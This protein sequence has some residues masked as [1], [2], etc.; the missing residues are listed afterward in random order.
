ME[1]YIRERDG[2]YQKD[3]EKIQ[4]HYTTTY[5]NWISLDAAK[6][7]WALK[8]RLKEIIESSTERRQN[9]F[10]LRTNGK[11]APVA[12]IGI[13]LVHI[14]ENLSKFESYCPVSLLDNGELVQGPTN[15]RFT[16]EYEVFK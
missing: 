6:S 7:K 15:T 1:K 3:I 5:Q 16:A 13:S 9:Y 10:S 4:N 8:S 14:S 2:N 12:D 11:A